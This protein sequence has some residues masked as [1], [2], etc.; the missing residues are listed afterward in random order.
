[1][2]GSSSEGCF[3]DEEVVQS[4]VSSFGVIAAFDVS[5]LPSRPRRFVGVQS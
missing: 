1:M 3:A 5:G 2:A 4:S